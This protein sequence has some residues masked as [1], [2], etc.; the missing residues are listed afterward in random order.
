MNTAT[1][2]ML[3]EDYNLNAENKNKGFAL[4]DPLFKEYGWHMTK[5]EMN[6]ISYTKFGQETDV[7]DIKI[8]KTAILVSI[9]I[10]NSPYQYITS[11]KD[12]YQANEFIE[13][14]FNDFIK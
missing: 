1:N 2:M 3:N 10:K 14:R 13:A 5:N 4:L 9:P 11:F 6:W 8:N 7:F 12:Y